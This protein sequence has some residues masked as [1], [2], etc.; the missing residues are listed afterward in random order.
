[1]V[2]AYI[3]LQNINTTTSLIQSISYFKTDILCLVKDIVVRLFMDLLFFSEK[4]KQETLDMSSSELGK[5]RSA[6]LL[7]ELLYV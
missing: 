2:T 7:K 5:T 4:E 6:V 3:P 1:M